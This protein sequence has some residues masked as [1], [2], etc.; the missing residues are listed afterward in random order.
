MTLDA[1]DNQSFRD[2]AVVFARAVVDGVAQIPCTLPSAQQPFDVEVVLFHAGEMVGQGRGEHPSL[3]EALADAARGAANASHLSREQRAETR[4]AI[5]LRG[6]SYS[7]VE[8]GERGVELSH[9]LVAVRRFER[10]LLRQ[11]IDEGKAYLL[12]VIDAALGPERA[13]VHKYYYAP[14][15][16]FEPKLHTI[17]TASTIFTLL[18][19]QAFAPDEALSKAIEQATGFLLS[20]QAR[21]GDARNY[22]AFYYSFDLRTREPEQKFVVGTTSKTIFTLIELYASTGEERYLEAARLGADWLLT[23]LRPGGGVR[24]YLRYREPGR[25]TLSKKESMLYTGQVLSAL[26]RMYGVTKAPSYKAG[27]KKI[28]DHLLKRVASQGCYLSDD[29]RKPNPI[30]SSWAILSLLDYVKVTDNRLA[31]NVT[32]SCAR[33]LLER[34]IDDREDVHR[35]GR[36]KRSLSSS[37][38]GWLAEV[39]SELYLYCERDDVRVGD[40]EPFKAAVVDVLRLLMQYTYTPESAFFAKRP[41]AAIG[42]VFWNAAE[43]YVRTDSVCHAMNAYVYMFDHLDEGVLVELPEPPLSQRLAAGDAAAPADGAATADDEGDEAAAAAGDAD[44]S[45]DDSE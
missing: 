16:A 36:W 35:F 32:Y 20:M 2:R 41:E 40:C 31:R 17:Y 13:G 30:S 11:R 28:A 44:E 19:L 7:F 25:W 37:G 29:Y 4:M 23:M 38:N 14:A 18:K 6:R 43:R 33:E 39:M 27:A 8:H 42:G 3:C 1:L 9:G 15:D 5:D 22:G 26:S 10:S 24:S 21:E 34:Q 45:D 12:R